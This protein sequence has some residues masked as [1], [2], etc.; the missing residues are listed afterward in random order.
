MN[1]NELIKKYDDVL[2]K[3]FNEFEE[4]DWKRFEKFLKELDGEMEDK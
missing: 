1:K 4:K 2:N 3:P